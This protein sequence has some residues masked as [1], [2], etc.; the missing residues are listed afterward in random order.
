MERV[1]YFKYGKAFSILANLYMSLNAQ[2]LISITKHISSFLL[3]LHHCHVQGDGVTS[4]SCT[5]SFCNHATHYQDIKM[6]D[7]YMYCCCPFSILYL[8]NYHI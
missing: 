5:I 4:H 8:T 6:N 7:A 1:L 3:K 2:L